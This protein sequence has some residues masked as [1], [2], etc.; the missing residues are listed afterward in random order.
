MHID[1]E[2]Q[3]VPQLIQGSHSAGYIVK[4]VAD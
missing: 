2:S 4:F 3:K 1:A